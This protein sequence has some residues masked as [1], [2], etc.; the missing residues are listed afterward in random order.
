MGLEADAKEGQSRLFKETNK[1]YQVSEG[2]IEFAVNR[3]DSETGEFSGVFVS[4]QVRLAPLSVPE[5][6]TKSAQHFETFET[7]PAG[8]TCEHAERNMMWIRFFISVMN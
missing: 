2:S 6:R 3:V 7:L 4:E 5:P 8:Y 1:I